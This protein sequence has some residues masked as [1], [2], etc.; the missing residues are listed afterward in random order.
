MARTTKTDILIPEIFN[1][2]IQAAFAGK[3]AFVGDSPLARSGALVV[4]DSFG[5]D[6]KSIGDTVK[7]PYFGTLGEF[8]SNSDGT[9]VTASKISQTSESATVS[10]D[11][12]AFEATRWAQSSMGGDAYMEGAR[13]LVV[14]ASR[15]MDARCLT[16]AVATGG[17]R[18]SLYS[19]TTPVY[20]DYDAMVDAKMAWGDEQDDIVAMAVHSATLADLFKLRDS[21]GR[22]LIS[23]PVE[24]GLPRFMGTPVMTSDRLPVTG[25]AMGSVTESGTTPPDIAITTNTPLGAWK[26]KILPVTTGAR[27]TAT[28]K[29]SLDNGENYSDP[30]LTAAS[31]SLVDPAIDSTI[32]V[33]GASGLV[34]SYENASS[35]SDNVWTAS[36]SLKART[37][38]LKRGALGFWYNRQALALQTDKDILQDSSVA[39]MH[40]YAAAIRYR[41]RPGGVKPGVVVVEHNV[42]SAP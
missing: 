38:L 3:D 18:K 33:N 29:F 39:A 23:D 5:G 2:A 4:S 36:C 26:L 17:L 42:R 7:V 6:A 37:L 34:I 25:S 27:G 41:R 9:A 11:S 15:A 16:A 40:L 21:T 1:E 35:T 24:G 14:A 10:R 32:G 22:P 13:Q 30:I 8:A 28:I 20:F 19:S 31:I 12:L